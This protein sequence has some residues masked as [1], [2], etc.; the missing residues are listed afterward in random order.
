MVKNDIENGFNNDIPKTRFYTNNGMRIPCFT[1][2]RC[3]NGKII[4]CFDF[5]GHHLEAEI[6]NETGFVEAFYLNRDTNAT[7][8][9]SFNIWSPEEWAAKIGKSKGNDDAR[10]FE[11]D[12]D[13][14]R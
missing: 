3:E 1:A 11:R 10:D 4:V 2:G 5:N 12:E 6:E 13:P 14:V 9:E 8:E 7:W